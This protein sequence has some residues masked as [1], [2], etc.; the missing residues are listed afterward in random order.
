[1]YLH[2]P[3]PVLT[4]SPSPHIASVPRRECAY[5]SQKGADASL[6]DAS[7]RDAA[8]L[9]RRNGH[10]PLAMLFQEGPPIPDPK[11]VFEGMDG[12]SLITAINQPA[13]LK[14]MLKRPLVGSTH[15]ANRRDIDG[16]RTPLHWAAAR[17]RSKCIKLL[18]AAGAS[19]D[20]LD[21]EGRTPLML[22]LE[23]R[24]GDAV[25]LLRGAALASTA[26]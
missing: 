9:A 14:E 3:H 25:H 7:G 21:A 17:N 23:L 10:E 4:P 12:C 20:V 26:A 6:V 19:T 8:E 1:M 13:R 2:L 5:T 16:D 18:L 11:Q 22:A 15:D 24:Q